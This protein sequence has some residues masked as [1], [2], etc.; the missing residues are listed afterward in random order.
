[1]KSVKSSGRIAWAV[2]MTAVFLLPA[3]VVAGEFNPAGWTVPS[4]YGAERYSSEKIDFD[5]RIKGEE[6]LLEKFVTLSGGRVYRYSYQGRIFSYEVDHDIE[7]PLDYEI[8][9]MDGSG[10]FETRQSPYNRYPLP[11]WTRK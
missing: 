9:D 8:V 1:M 3:R 6:V 10:L 2:M 11:D 4:L 5:P 7:D